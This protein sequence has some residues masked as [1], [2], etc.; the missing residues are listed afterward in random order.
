MKSKKSIALI[1]QKKTTQIKAG[2][3]YGGR[4]KSASKIHNK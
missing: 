2:K 1:E 3:V 4:S